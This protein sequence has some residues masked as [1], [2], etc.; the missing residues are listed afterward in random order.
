M[1]VTHA[2][3]LPGTSLDDYKAM[4]SIGWPVIVGFDIFGDSN[5]Q[6]KYLFGDYTNRTGIMLM[7]PTPV[8]GRTNGHA[9][10]F[11][12]YNDNTR[13]IKFK[14]SW[15]TGRGDR[16]YYYMP[17]DYLRWTHDAWVFW[18]QDIQ[19]LMS[20]AGASFSGVGAV[21]TTD[22]E[23]FAFSEGKQPSDVHKTVVAA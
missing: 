15:G 18:G 1:K 4:L 7:P 3:R 2:Y 6:R 14:N 19:L 8:P 12:G 13:L 21:A 5:Y 20:T 9:V 17:Y 11:V 16:G 22:E 10:V 23:T